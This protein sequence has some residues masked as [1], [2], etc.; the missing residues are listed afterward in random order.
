MK[1]FTNVEE[2]NELNSKMNLTEIKETD[3]REIVKGIAD[4]CDVDVI[5]TF[6]YPLYLV[7]LVLKNKAR[8][9]WLDGR[10]GVTVNL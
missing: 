3:V 5:K 6:Y 8:R 1:Q 2:I 7:E 9:M 10:T 4:G